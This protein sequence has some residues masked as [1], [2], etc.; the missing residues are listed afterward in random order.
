MAPDI[1]SLLEGTAADAANIDAAEFEKL[2]EDI[3]SDKAIKEGTVVTGTVIR[4]TDDFVV[5]DID[6]KS[7]GVIPA[8]EFRPKDA[9]RD[10][11]LPVA[12]GDEV[13]VYLDSLEGPDGQL[14][15][16]KDKADL[17]KAWDRI[18][19][20]VDNDEIVEGTIIARVKGGLSVDIGVKAFLPGSQV[21]LRP[22][23]NLERLIGAVAQFKIIKFNKR[24]GNIVLSRRVLLEAERSERRDETLKKIKVGAI[25]DGTVKN[26][27]DYGAFIDLGGID[28]LLHITDMSWGRINHPTE[29]FDIGD[30][31]QVRI[32]K[33]DQESQRVSLGYKQLREDPWSHVGDRYPIGA[34]VKGKVV[35]MPDYG[36]FI[37]LEE[38]IE[39]LVHISEMTWNKR[40]KHPSK[41]VDLEQE[42]EAVVLDVDLEN[43]RISLGMKQLDENPWDLVEQQHPVG[44]LL[45]GTVRNITDFGIFIG[46]EDGIDGLVHISDL[47]WSQRI[48]HPSERYK[49]G[50]EVEAKVLKIDKLGER[51]S[52]GVK[53]LS[54]DPW[55]SVPGRYFLSQTLEGKVVHHADF[56]IFVELEEGVEGLLHIS[57]LSH[58]I[59]SE[60]YE[61]NKKISIEI[62]SID[63]HDQKI[64]LAEHREGTD[65]PPAVEQQTASATLGDTAAA[66]VLAGLKLAPGA[67]EPDEPA[68][69]AQ[70]TAAEE[71]AVEEPAAD[72]PAAD[73]PAA[74]EPEAEE[75]AAEEP[76]AEEAAEEPASEEPA[77]D[78]EAAES[79]DEDSAEADE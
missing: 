40:I 74:G 28:G 15:L 2:F 19:E 32:L 31:V 33:Y 25:I 52:L 8:W 55:R 13:E 77:A 20:A 69:I 9:P 16:S 57:E 61:V 26:I 36:A 75:P 70:E 30:E 35:S 4:M 56:G 5:V 73:E 12:V 27:T 45:S 58:D 54:E 44:S 38:G 60:I 22:V 6:Y 79:A 1:N 46:I 3:I 11:P 50:D 7:E 76:V 48:K 42:V 68:Q 78:E 23:K 18:Q 29:M 37:E 66:G 53:Q 51:F 62:I 17:M 43:K 47:S 71:P 34:V 64:G 21:D 39:G 24:R 41:L 59:T 72:E 10:T 67:G 63:P 14:V 65:A 49:K